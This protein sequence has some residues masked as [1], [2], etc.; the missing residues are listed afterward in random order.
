MALNVASMRHS[1]SRY[2]GKEY[3][4]EKEKGKLIVRKRI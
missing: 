4:K 3:G 2:T 1:N